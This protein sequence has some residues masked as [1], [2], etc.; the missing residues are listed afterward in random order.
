[1]T[2]PRPRPTP[3]LRRLERIAHTFGVS[4]AREK[5]ALLR[6]LSRTRLARAAD[7][8]RFHEL[9]CFLAA[10]PDDERVHALVRRVLD[11]FDR[12]T[13]LRA[14]ASALASSGIAGTTIEYRFFAPMAQWLAARW[15]DRLRIDWDE[16][17]ESERLEPLLP[18]L[19]TAA[20]AP[21]LDEYDLGLREWIAR[22]AGPRETDAAFLIRRLAQLGLPSELHETLY[23]SLDPPMR[24]APGRDTP[25]RSRDHA[26]I[27]R[28][29]HQRSP[30]A[31]ARP[32][33]RVEAMRSPRSVRA[34]SAREGQAYIDLA[35]A[36]MVTRSRDL[37]AF[38]N[39]D[40]RDVRLVEFDGGLQF[41]CLGVRPER[42]LL[43]E[44][45][46]GFLTLKNGVPTGYVLTSALYGSCELAYNV[47]ET[48]RGAEAAHTYAR[49][50]AMAR[51]LFHADTFTIYPYQLGDGNEEGIESGAWWFYYKL[52]FRPRSRAI[53]RRVDVELRRI[54]ARPKHR[55][56]PAT[57]RALAKD[58]VYLSLGRERDDIIGHV[59]LANVGIAVT[60]MIA[61][62]FG[63]DRE[64]AERE[65]ADEAATRFGV[66]TMRGW[67]A[68][69]RMAWN[70]WGPVVVLLPG[71][72][73]W[74][75]VER[76]ALVEVVRAKGGPRESDFV[77]RFDQHARL[78]RALAVLAR[79]TKPD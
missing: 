31:Q 12:R 48:Y 28:I 10:Y 25:S 20:E 16:F 30:L 76:T 18:H 21:G 23:D 79:G 36:A 77:R 67:S 38:S 3:S 43:L 24:L 34:L 53:L 69:E 75:R 68:G 2:R 39:A 22:L 46:Y 49:V 42:R 29:H 17:D 54:S 61:R 1:M 57:L 11:R 59:P 41:A 58:N 45:V 50:I 15:P 44:S 66:K 72:Q 35:H 55:S 71:V 56:T 32:D 52:G 13:D 6:A 8:S 33:L 70:R 7:V 9:L 14:H 73:R 65:L 47:F 78:R 63:Y 60:R 26:P 27:A 74:S 40:P 51:G 4:T 62:R 64:R 37:D 19:A 5:L